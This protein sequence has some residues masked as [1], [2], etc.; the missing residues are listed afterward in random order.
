MPITSAIQIGYYFAQ[1]DGE[2]RPE[3]LE[4]FESAASA[5]DRI[6]EQGGDDFWG[7][8]PNLITWDE[9]CDSIAS[10][11]AF[12]VDVES[13]FH[14]Y[15]WEPF[16]RDLVGLPDKKALPPDPEIIPNLSAV[17]H[18]EWH[19]TK[20]GQ[21]A[22]LGESLP[23]LSSRGAWV[24][25]SRGWTIYNRNRNVTGIGRFPFKS[26]EEANAWIAKESARRL[27]YVKSIDSTK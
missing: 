15:D 26:E 25:R 20:T 3:I 16:L 2:L 19:N 12:H 17:R 6:E 13:L 21:T 1:H 11:I 24:I 7:D 10:H 8:R 5:L 27:A 14:I 23:L 18:K 9:V 22:S 4:L